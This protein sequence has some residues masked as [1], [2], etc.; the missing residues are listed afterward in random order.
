MG[1]PSASCT[2]GEDGQRSR[3]NGTAS[4]A[5][6][7]RHEVSSSYLGGDLQRSFPSILSADRELGRLADQDAGLL[8]A[9]TFHWVIKSKRNIDETVG[10]AVSG[11]RRMRWERM[12][13][14]LM[15][16]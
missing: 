10:G 5:L 4:G 14:F 3:S 2:H 9:G 11:C 6:G 7:M 1:S 13:A 8:E 16:S 12:M 15:W